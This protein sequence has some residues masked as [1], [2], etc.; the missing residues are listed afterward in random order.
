MNIHDKKSKKYLEYL[1]SVA[2]AARQS[3]CRIPPGDK[4][5]TPKQPFTGETPTTTIQYPIKHRKS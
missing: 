5:K 1:M 2:N 4:Y 3:T